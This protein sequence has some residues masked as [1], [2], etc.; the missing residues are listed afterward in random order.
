MEL[1]AKLSMV[2]I[3]LMTA[4]LLFGSIIAS[5]TSG[6]LGVPALL[7]FMGI[8]MIVGSDGLNWIPFNNAALAQFLGVVALIFIIGVRVYRRHLAHALLAYPTWRA[9]LTGTA[10]S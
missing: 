7:L 9:A 6:R 10:F 8:G 5:K 1:I 2:D 4:L 3:L